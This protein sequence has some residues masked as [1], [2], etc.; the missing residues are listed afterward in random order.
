M[1]IYLIGFMGC[2]K[3]SIAKRL[4]N[5][6]NF[7]FLDMDDMLEKEYHI[8]ISDLF[9]KYGEEVFRKLEQTVLQKT[10]SMVNTVISTGGGNPCFKNNMKT[11]N[12][13]GI[14]IYLQLSPKMLIHRLENSKK[15]RPLIKKIPEEQRLKYIEELLKEREKFYL[16]ATHIVDGANIEIPEIIKLLE[17]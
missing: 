6:L 8:T 14:S 15:P 16:Q 9:L 7:D 12:D 13:N 17:I 4:A 3:T 5:K 11:I 10:L 1:L 2:G